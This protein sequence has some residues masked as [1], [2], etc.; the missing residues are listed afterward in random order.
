M[1][2][3]LRSNFPRGSYLWAV[4][5]AQWHALGIPESDCE[6]PKIAVVRSEER[7]VGKEC[8]SRWSPY[9]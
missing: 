5:N 7:R 6:K 2:R 9:H 1:K 8:R 4:R 3:E